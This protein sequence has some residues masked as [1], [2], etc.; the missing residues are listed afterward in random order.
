MFPISQEGDKSNTYNYRPIEEN[1][2]FF[3]GKLNEGASTLNREESNLSMNEIWKET[4]EVFIEAGKCVT[5]TT[6]Q[7]NGPWISHE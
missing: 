7:S 1:F 5:P 6:M 3:L 2:Q 4:K